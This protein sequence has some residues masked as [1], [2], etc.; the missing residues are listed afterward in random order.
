MRYI[1]DRAVRAVLFFVILSWI[2]ITIT[3]GQNEKAGEARVKVHKNLISV[4]PSAGGTAVTVAGNAGAIDSSSAA[5]LKITNLSTNDFVEAQIQEDGSFQ[6]DIEAAAADQIQVL[7]TNKQGK[8]SRGTFRVPP[9]AEPANPNSAPKTL[10]VKKE[11]APLPKPAASGPV[12]EEARELTVLVVVL[13]KT[14]GEIL[15]SQTRQIAAKADVE[16][17]EEN[18]YSELIEKIADQCARTIR[19]KIITPNKP[20]AIVDPQSNPKSVEREDVIPAEPN[21]PIE[22]G[23]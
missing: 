14:T 9:A 10:P 3:S 19:E 7:A 16:E 23:T 6:A 12:Q 20:N 4:T 11:A 18:F 1:K 21:E 2:P 17:K 13:D 8:K 5:E 22:A 15:S